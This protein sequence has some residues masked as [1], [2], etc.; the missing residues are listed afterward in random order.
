MKMWGSGGTT[1]SILHFGT[2]IEESVRLHA[3]AALPPGKISP[4]PMDRKL[5]GLESRCGIGG[6]EI[7][8]CWDS[9]SEFA[10]HSQSLY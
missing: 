6:E 10:A 3:Q 8:P 1:P 9:N 5:V 7:S 2:S 4:Y